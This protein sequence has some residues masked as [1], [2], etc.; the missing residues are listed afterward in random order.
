MNI[1]MRMNI[2]MTMNNLIAAMNTVQ[3]P[4]LP[5]VAGR[6]RRQGS[7]KSESR[8]RIVQLHE[9][10]PV[11]VA[12]LQKS[13]IADSNSNKLSLKWKESL[14]LDSMSGKVTPSFCDLVPRP[15]PH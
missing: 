10:L 13:G 2:L 11:A 4:S 8:M 3:R 14:N 7:M 12:V 15:H 5:D 6:H 1:L 9:S